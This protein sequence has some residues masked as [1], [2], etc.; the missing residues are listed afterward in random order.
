MNE[1]METSWLE[2]IRRRAKVERKKTRLRKEESS[3]SL[4]VVAPEELW[5]RIKS[6]STSFRND[7]TTQRHCHQQIQKLPPPNTQTYA[8]LLEGTRLYNEKMNPAKRAA[9]MDEV[10]KDLILCFEQ[11]I[12]GSDNS[13][14]RSDNYAQQQQKLVLHSINK[15]CSAWVNGKKVQNAE[16]WLKQLER[17]PTIHPQRETY[18]IVLSGWNK[19]NLPRHAE[20]ILYRMKDYGI[21]PS[22]HEIASCLNAWAKSS[23]PAAGP[24]AE[25]LLLQLHN[26]YLEQQQQQKKKQEHV[27]KTQNT[28]DKNDVSPVIDR[29][30]L[31]SM[32]LKVLKTWVDAS[33]KT[34]N[35]AADRAEK[36]L[37]LLLGL[38]N[39]YSNNSN[40]NELSIS[41]SEI[42]D[43][44]M[45][46]AYLYTMKGW[47]FVGEPDK[48]FHLW[49]KLQTR[50]QQQQQQQQQ[51]H[52]DTQEQ[53]A[54][55]HKVF[56]SLMT[57]L[58]RLSK[59][60][61]LADFVSQK[62]NEWTAMFAKQPAWI[63]NVDT[64]NALLQVYAGI[65]NGP[66]A[67]QVLRYMQEDDNVTPDTK[68]YNLV[69]LAWSRSSLE[70]EKHDR[71]EDIFFEMKDR[72]VQPDNVTYKALLSALEG[73]GERGYIHF[74]EL[75]DLYRRTQDLLLRPDTV[76]YTKAIALFNTPAK[77]DPL[78]FE[79]AQGIFDE[80]MQQV[81]N[82]NKFL[83]PTFATGQALISVLQKSHVPDKRERIR[84]IR[85]TI[86][87]LR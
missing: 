86:L 14:N 87:D 67:E 63:W 25:T 71:A 15:V 66:Q 3:A 60:H 83:T 41:A 7:A 49:N 26:L 57:G 47:S 55:L 30:V 53:Q 76:A 74:T 82:G 85:Q 62:A 2:L 48:V 56:L 36:V 65:G 58:T 4:R 20:S 40:D 24:R 31:A 33:G 18:S 59:K 77:D 28:N 68:T 46:E 64:Y 70:E 16:F 51:N 73:T 37:Q 84:K 19:V 78:A 35:N 43:S 34:R 27:Q 69:L 44:I 38:E 29:Q 22:V 5:T 52:S 17:H 54:V 75:V 23:D 72:F 81:A 80:M 39:H 32:L 79:R 50:Q 6:S 10:L 21:A 11:E 1:W 8:L 45:T 61:D 42:P 12:R 9:L 13:D